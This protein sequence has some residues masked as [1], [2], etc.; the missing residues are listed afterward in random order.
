MSENLQKEIAIIAE[1]V[2]SFNPNN[3]CL[4]YSDYFV[5]EKWFDIVGC[6]QKVI[7]ALSIALPNYL[8]SN[9]KIKSLK[10]I[11]KNVRDI[12]VNQNNF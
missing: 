1:F 3:F 9:K 8:S 4:A 5:I 12:L 11:D 6:S 10:L 7:Y 2:L